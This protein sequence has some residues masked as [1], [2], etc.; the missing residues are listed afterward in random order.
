MHWD[1][2]LRLIVQALR[3][4][5][6]I[7]EAVPWDAEAVAWDRFDLV[8][9]R[10]AWDY[11]ERIGEFL[12]WAETTA[13]LTRLRNPAT[14]VCWNSDKRYLLDL[15]KQGVAVVPTLFI[16]PGTQ[17]IRGDFE[18]IG[19]VV[20]KPAISAGAV[21]TARY[22]PHQSADAMQHA[23]MLLGQGR[24]VMVQ[25]YLR[26][27]EE[28]ERALVF[29]SGTF[30][31]AIR[32]GPVLTEPGVLDNDRVPHPDVARYTPTAEEVATAQTALAAVPS[33][34]P[35][36]F[37]RVDLVLDD[38]RI[39]TVMELELIEPNLFLVDNPR[40]LERLAGS[41]FAEAREAAS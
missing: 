14:V 38:N 33:L 28:G 25:P 19:G 40:G 34:D 16:E 21:D 39:P 17:P 3:D 37:A 31:H 23:E 22:E 15:A 29:V 1:A 27:V 11:A 10:S 9:I 13:R 6:S 41:V 4:S 2:D 12:A 26:L 30:S 7:A 24:V 32:K 8:V 20:V 5:G 36:L 18:R 35:P